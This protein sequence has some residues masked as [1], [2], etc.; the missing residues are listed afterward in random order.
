MIIERLFLLSCLFPW[1]SF[2]VLDMD[3]QPYSLVLG[4]LVIIKNYKRVNDYRLIYPI[5]MV[6]G[7]IIV[8]LAYQTIDFLALRAIASYSS[9]FIISASFLSLGI[10]KQTIVSYFSFAS[11]IWASAA[12]VQVI[13]GAE[14]LSFLM[15]TR[16]SASRGVTSLA[17]E[18]T[19]YGIYLIFIT[20]ILLQFHDYKASHMGKKEKIAIMVNFISLFLF[21]K[22]T[23]A[24]LFLFVIISI[25]L[26]F[27]VIRKMKISSIVLTIMIVF[28][29]FFAFN[30][31]KKQAVGSRL[32]DISEQVLNV[33]VKDVVYADASINQ[34]VKNVVL[35]IEGAIDSYFIPNGYHQFASVSESLKVK[36]D[37]FFWWGEPSNIILSGIGSAMFELGIMFVFLILYIYS[38]RRKNEF[39]MFEFVTMVTLMFSAIPLSFPLFSMVC[40]NSTNEKNN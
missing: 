15:E 28:M 19:F 37:G 6:S 7:S 38:F 26:L 1:V 23:M 5:L 17:P 4:A 29:S 36:Y 21:S 18:P 33:G 13:F 25:Y 22:S 9:V 31:F 40:V 39:K 2:R 24:I 12:L 14:V 20:W 8:A 30:A 11:F 34:R 10:A 16:T 35:S 27:N 3:M 32:Y